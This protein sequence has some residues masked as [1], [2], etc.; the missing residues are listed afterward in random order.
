[1][2]AIVARNDPNYNVAIKQLPCTEVAIETFI[3]F[4]EII[5]IFVYALLYSYRFAQRRLSTPAARAPLR[6]RA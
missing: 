3:N 2:R 4:E 5:I 6:A 1:M